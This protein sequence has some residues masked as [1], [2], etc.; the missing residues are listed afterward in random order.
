MTTSQERPDVE[1]EL[2]RLKDFQ[3]ATVEHVHRRFWEDKDP[4]KRFLVADEVGLGK[5]LVARGVITKTL[6]KLW[7][8]EDRIDVVYICSNTQI[9]KQNLSRLAIGGFSVD[10]ADRLTMLPEA[11]K[12]LRKS[13]VNFISFTPGTSFHI[14]EAGGK[15]GERILLQ[16]M[17]AKAWGPEVRRN[18]G[19]IRFFRGGVGEDNYSRHV[20]EYDDRRF[21]QVLAQRFAVDVEAATAYTGRPLI[22]ELDETVESFRYL[23]AAVPHKL[24]RHRYRLIGQMRNLVAQA[25]VESLEPDL[26]ILDEF[27]RFKDLLDPEQPGADLAHA[28][29]DQPTARVLLLS[30]TPYKM[31]TLPDEA[32]G[33]DH[34]AD[35][36]R[37]VEFLAGDE[38]AGLVMSGLRTMRESLLRK[39]DHDVAKA[40]KDEVEQRL[41]KVMA[42]TERLRSTTDLDGMLAE[43]PVPGARVTAD[44]LL[45]YVDASRVAQ[46][47]DAQ[48]VFEYWRASPY[49]FNIMEGY[50]VKKKLNAALSAP[51][52]ALTD[53]LAHA[54]GL[55]NWQQFEAYT[56]LDPGN[57]KM[58]GLMSDVLDRGAWRL[59]WLPPALPYYEAGGAYADSELQTFTKRLIFSAWAVVPKA[60][61]VVMS[62]EAER[63]ALTEAGTRTTTRAYSAE[64]PTGLLRFQA[65]ASGRLTGMPV[66]ALL[67]PSITLARH[68]DPL[69]A[70]RG[71]GFLPVGRRDVL[72]AVESSLAGALEQL[73]QG[74]ATSQ[75]DQ[76]WYWAAPFLL[77]ALL[78]PE[79]QEEFIEQMVDWGDN[80]GD[81]KDS[82]LAK[83]VAEARDLDGGD[84]G[85]RPDDLAA[86]LAE[87]AVAGPGVAALRAL[88]RVCGGDTALADWYIRD[89]AA[90]VSWGLRS[91]FNRPESMSIVRTDDGE[92]YWRAVVKHC[93]DGNLQAV[94]DEYAHVLLDSEGLQAADVH[95]RAVGISEAMDDALTLRATRASVDDISRSNGSFT[96]TP[97]NVRLHFAARF[98]RGQDEESQVQRE[99]QVRAAY[100]SPFWPFVLASTSVGQE[101]LDFHQY[102]HA[103]VHWNLPGNP[104]DLEQREGRVHRFKGHAI[105]RNVAMTHS[106]A[107]LNVSAPD[108]WA[109]MFDAVREEVDSEN[110]LTPYWVYAPAGGAQIERYVPAAPL[111]KEAARYQRLMRTVGAYRLVMGQPRQ[112]DLLRY[113][114]DEVSALEWLR[115][116]LQ[117]ATHQ[118]EEA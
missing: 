74:T 34:Y 7:D 17:L 77:D 109:A 29:F 24:S 9:A 19:W 26:V 101:G 67:Y 68:G 60:I 2:S 59:L 61:G 62:Y 91:L 30:A 5:T 54:A 85:R 80:D 64:R 88:S 69:A 25:A 42:R 1:R 41:R 48:D 92:P 71:A 79:A 44:D 76:R 90:T 93:I 12:D 94:L 51:P 28:I 13:K 43:L 57:A 56:K 108:P 36:R 21:D 107:A 75:V 106:E 105:R 37:T 53:A 98:G 102:S 8:V 83:H 81:E 114:G 89:T 22:E 58:R 31:Y 70:A 52:L 40:A 55:L 95:D 110:D 35:F 33:D 111:S 86:V 32:E 112:E 103:V 46:A 63:R 45:A 4:S 11:L 47:L 3:R 73:P 96:L 18:K 16:R 65:D 39:E 104:V 66:L 6:E 118:A 78:E 50:Q 113:L 84:L 100:N 23:R 99:G 15:E 14:Q 49:V 27:Q 116:D 97:H 115:I 20:A 10:H 72:S 38:E 117:P 82:Q 87:L